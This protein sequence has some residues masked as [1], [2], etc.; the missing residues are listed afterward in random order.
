MT[1]TATDQQYNPVRDNNTDDRCPINTTV[2][3][4]LAYMY[5]IINMH[6]MNKDLAFLLCL[7][8]SLYI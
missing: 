1:P 6:F 7:N 3:C 5:N 8:N 4:S 2:S